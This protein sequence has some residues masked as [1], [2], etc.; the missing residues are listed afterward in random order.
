MFTTCTAARANSGHFTPR[1]RDTRADEAQKKKREGGGCVCLASLN[2]KKKEGSREVR[3]R[4]A[5][6]EA[7]AG[8]EKK[9]QHINRDRVE[10]RGCERG[11]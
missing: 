1:H 2:G 4:E 7:T 11:T 5:E 8:E 10:E 9:R 3:V 6:E